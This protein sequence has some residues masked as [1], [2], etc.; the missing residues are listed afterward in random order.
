MLRVALLQLN[1]TANPADNLA[2]LKPLFTQAVERGAQFILTPECTNFLAARRADTLANAK[3]EAEDLHA[4][5]LPTWAKAA[6]VW[7]LAGSLLL[8]AEEGRLVNRQL[9]W[10]PEGQRVTAYDK[11]HLFDVEVGDGQH[12]AESKT[13]VAGRSMQTTPTPFAV[14]GHAICY[15]LRFPLLFRKLAQ[16]GA[17]LLLLPA[18]FTATTG[19]AHW[20][21]LIRA[22]AIETGSFVLAPAQGGL[23]DG[24]RQ[25]WGRS[26]LVEPWGQVVAQLD[27][28]QPGV[29]FADLD[30]EAV[31]TARARIP[32]WR[33][34][35]PYRLA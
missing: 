32:A 11:I 12:Y 8:Q 22:R 5:T 1:V 33:L 6:G 4:Q 34:D 7:L 30:L 35:A 15:D 23:H 17:E 16:A 14:L 25:T 9:L 31:R 20:E 18:A 19:A 24:G 28:D 27:H 26:C 29:L 2:A 10:N 3:P 13:F 21:T